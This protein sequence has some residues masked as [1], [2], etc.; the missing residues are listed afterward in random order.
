MDQKLGIGIGMLCVAVVLGIA[1][2]VYHVGVHPEWTQ[3]QAF[4]EMWLLY[5]T[6]IALSIGSIVVMGVRQ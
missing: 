1:A 3:A 2:T 5:L 4:R 6:C